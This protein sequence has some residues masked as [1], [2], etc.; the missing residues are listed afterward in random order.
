MI[1]D[2]RIPSESETGGESSSGDVSTEWN[3]DEQDDF[4]ASV[5]C[6]EW[7]GDEDNKSLELGTHRDVYTMVKKYPQTPAEWKVYTGLQLNQLQITMDLNSFVKLNWSWLGANN[8]KAVSVDP[9]KEEDYDV[10]LTT[11]SFKTLEGAFYIGDT[12]G[13]KTTQIRQSSNI[14]ITI[15]NNKERTDALFETKA[16]EMSDGDFVV[17]GSFDIWKADVLATTLENYAIDGVKKW[18]SVTVARGNVSYEI[19]MLAKLKTPSESKDGN[20]LKTTINFSI[21]DNGGIK[22][23]KKVTA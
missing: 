7:E 2:T 14:N 12:Q 13:A 5:M 10:P 17:E 19:Q 4:F 3:I 21:H 22:I 9:Y 1:P 18:L 15:N 23:I 16:I 20:K 11:K 6:S 8:P